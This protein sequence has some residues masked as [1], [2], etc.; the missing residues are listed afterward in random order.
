MKHAMT[1][2]IALAI[3]VFI[4]ARWGGMIPVIGKTGA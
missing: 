1:F 2:I 4:G 3:G